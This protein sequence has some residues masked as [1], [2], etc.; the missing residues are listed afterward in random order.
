MTIQNWPVCG[1]KNG[2]GQV[3]M[4]S[5]LRFGVVVDMGVKI[6]LCITKNQDSVNVKFYSFH[7]NSSGID[8]VGSS[9][10]YHRNVLSSSSSNLPPP[11]P[12]APLCSCT[13]PPSAVTKYELGDPLLKGFLVSVDLFR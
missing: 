7:I 8:Y 13:P 10:L 1:V 4:I 9:Q 12:S 2:V 3:K 6:S 11:P 5:F